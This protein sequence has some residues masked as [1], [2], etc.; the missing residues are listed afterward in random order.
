MAEN[1]TSQEE[2]Q[3]I[4]FN[5]VPIAVGTLLKTSKKM[6]EHL[7]FLDRKVEDIIGK[8]AG[9][10]SEW[11]SPQGLSDYLPD[12]PAVPTIYGWTHFNKV[13]FC[14]KGKKLYFNRTSIDEWLKSGR[15]KTKKEIRDE[16]IKS[17]NTIK[18]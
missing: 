6:Q 12:H 14:K 1:K 3:G 11:L 13:P 16:I 2:V 4:S 15:K 8:L 7:E 18:N 17:I 10:Q 5:D 9:N